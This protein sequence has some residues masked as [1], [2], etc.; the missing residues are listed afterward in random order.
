MSVCACLP[1]PLWQSLN[2]WAQFELY[3]GLES[4]LALARCGA[5]TPL[6][7][8]AELNTVQLLA[9]VRPRAAVRTAC[10]EAVFFV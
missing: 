10:R 9:E 5:L 4:A 6:A 3:G 1:I 8:W 2:E 7:R